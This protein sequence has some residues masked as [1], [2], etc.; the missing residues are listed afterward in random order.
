MFSPVQR[1]QLYANDNGWPV[2]VYDSSVCRV[3]CRREDGRLCSVSIREFSHQA[4][5]AGDG[6]DKNGDNTLAAGYKI[7]QQTWTALT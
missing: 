6:A 1:G 4:G 2:T 7:K 3:V 5:H